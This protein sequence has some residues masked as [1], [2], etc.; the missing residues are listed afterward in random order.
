[1]KAQ[2][3]N[4]FGD[5]SVFKLTNLPIPKV[6]PGHVLI[7][8]Y[9]TSINPIDCKIRSGMASAIAPEFPAILHGDVAGTV[10]IVGDGVDDFREGDEIYGCAGGFRGLGG[11]LAEFMLVDAKLIA[12]K[13]KSLSIEEAA[14]LPLV[15][16]TSWI[17][18]FEK[19]KLT[20]KMEILIHGGVGG[21]GH[22][23]IQ[24]AKWC[25]AKVYTTVRSNEDFH[26][27][28][29]FGADEVINSQEEDVDDYKL[30]LTN[31]NGFTTIFDTVGGANLDK[32][33]AAASVNG[34]IVTIA[35]RSTND[36]THM[37]NKGLSLHC[38]FMITPFLTNKYREH[39]GNI[40]KQVAQIVDAGK[41]K[42]LKDSNKFTLEDIS[43]AHELLESGKSKGKVIISIDTRQY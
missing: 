16:I 27:A 36:L 4:S 38:V 41:L 28:K 18:L 10:E 42:V 13:P 30:R 37:H 21:V 19:A 15:S 8:V 31:E 26:I 12:K 5:P 39:Y 2:V 29:S 35:A 9:A 24:L 22:I 11:A 25:G 43:H 6:K 7:K 23:A 14:A 34:T 17:A 32:S 40:L 20:N 33:F 1:M 3:I